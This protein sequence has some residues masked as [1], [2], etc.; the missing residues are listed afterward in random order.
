[1][2]A[3][4]SRCTC[5]RGASTLSGK[6]RNNLAQRPHSVATQQK[7][8]NDGLQPHDRIQALRHPQ[9][10]SFQLPTS[11]CGL[12]DLLQ[13]CV[14]GESRPH[15]EQGGIVFMGQKEIAPRER[16]SHQI[17]ECIFWGVF[18]LFH[19]HPVGSRTA[20]HGHRSPMNR[21]DL[22]LP[23]IV[24]VGVIQLGV[25]LR[26][27]RHGADVLFG[28]FRRILRIAFQDQRI[29]ACALKPIGEALVPVLSLDASPF[30]QH[31]KVATFIQIRGGFARQLAT[32]LVELKRVVAK[33]I[34]LR[35]SQKERRIGDDEVKLAADD[36]R[37]SVAGEELDPLDSV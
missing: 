37:E 15:R 7:F 22:M 4:H 34:L 10:Q 6:L 17:P 9:G 8:S 2:A 31:L 1:M 36:R 3:K 19:Q 11:V 16:V 24:H 12:K 20:V 30:A 33:E 23:V 35:R 27:W 26:S 13:P 28:V 18:D 25:G 21:D 14:R 29:A 5:S 32:E